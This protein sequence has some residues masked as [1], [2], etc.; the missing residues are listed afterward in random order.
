M[1]NFGWS[2]PPGVSSIPGDYDMTASYEIT[3]PFTYFNDDNE[4][5]M[6][7]I[8]ECIELI[9]YQVNSIT[10]N[11]DGSFTAIITYA[12]DLDIDPH[13]M[14]ESDIECIIIEHLNNTY[15]LNIDVNSDDVWFNELNI[16]R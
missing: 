16:H 9:D 14:D 1:T 11:P 7:V 2:Y 8:A 13:G 3:F 15:N 5:H 10:S 6:Q 4:D 12:D